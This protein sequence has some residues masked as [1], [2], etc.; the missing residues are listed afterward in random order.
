MLYLQQLFVAFCSFGTEF[1][2]NALSFQAS[3]KYC[4]ITQREEHQLQIWIFANKLNLIPFLNRLVAHYQACMILQAMVSAK[5]ITKRSAKKIY[6]CILSCFSTQDSQTK[7]DFS[8]AHSFMM[9]AVI[10]F[11]KENISLKNVMDWSTFYRKLCVLKRSRTEKWP[12]GQQNKNFKRSDKTFG[13][14]HTIFGSNPHWTRRRKRKQVKPAVV[15]GIVARKQHANLRARIQC[16]LGLCLITPQIHSMF[17]PIV[18]TARCEQM[19]SQ[20]CQQSRSSFGELPFRKRTCILHDVSTGK[21]SMSSMQLSRW[22]VFQRLPGGRSPKSHHNF[23]RTQYQ[24]SLSQNNPCQDHQGNPF[25]DVSVTSPIAPA[26]KRHGYLVA[27]ESFHP[28]QTISCQH[29]RRGSAEAAQSDTVLPDGEAT[30]DSFAIRWL[31]NPCWKMAK[32]SSRYSYNMTESFLKWLVNVKIV[33]RFFSKIMTTVNMI[34]GTVNTGELSIDRHLTP[35]PNGIWEKSWETQKRK[36]FNST[37]TSHLLQPKSHFKTTEQFVMVLCH[38]QNISLRIRKLEIQ[39]VDIVFPVWTTHILQNG[40]S[41]ATV[42][43]RTDS[44]NSKNFTQHF[45]VNC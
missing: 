5:K 31:I 37:G 6:I 19:F 2:Q 36:S 17:W 18:A 12:K 13:S 11:R 16:G 35:K 32:T 44:S 4:T 9:S 3:T 23:L 28:W 34:L 27:N 29:T 26:Q 14:F 21:S 15:S 20:W 25:K 45:D 22:P 24:K 33:S 10:T 30:R 7:D 41:D 1:L 8:L 43:D 40:S 39:Q 38:Q 42:N